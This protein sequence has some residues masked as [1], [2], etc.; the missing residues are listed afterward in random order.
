MTN[1]DKILA[2]MKELVQLEE[3]TKRLHDAEETKRAQELEV[4]KRLQ[5][6]EDTKR[7]SLVYLS[8]PQ[9]TAPSSKDGS[10]GTVSASSFFEMVSSRLESSLALNLL[11]LTV[12]QQKLVDCVCST[13]TKESDLYPSLQKVLNK[14]CEGGN[15]K[16]KDTSQNAYLYNDKPDWSFFR[17]MSQN[18]EAGEVVFLGDV[19][20]SNN[21]LSTPSTQGQ[22]LSYAQR[23]LLAQPQRDFVFVVLYNVKTFRFYRV[24]RSE[25]EIIQ[26]CEADTNDGWAKLNY[27]LHQ[28]P[29]QLGQVSKDILV[30][31]QR[32][33][34]GKVLG[35]GA[36]AAV[37]Q[38]QLPNKLNVAIKVF[39]PNLNARCKSETQILTLLADNGVTGVPSLVAH[40]QETFVMIPV[41]VTFTHFIFLPQHFSQ[42]LQI[43]SE[44]HQRSVFHRDIAP[45]NIGLSEHRV[46]LLDWSHAIRASSEPAHYASLQTAPDR[47]LHNDVIPQ[48]S[49]EDDL[50]AA[51][52]TCYMLQNRH[53]ESLFRTLL[54]K[55]MLLN[56]WQGV[57]SRLNA[58]GEAEEC[59]DR[60]LLEKL[61]GSCLLLVDLDLQ[62]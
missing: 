15:F 26:W 35:R 36:S 13:G 61:R 41:C 45:R 37:F 47:Y 7:L 30:S 16:F 34:L 6:Q 54:T 50:H 38:S 5:Q 9:D 62:L 3:E 58:F 46:I 10:A 60:G 25:T 48:A 43:I 17:S 56:F 57:R 53:K 21:S 28:S 51:L 39:K 31:G 29:Q 27:L 52:R 44:A 32:F 59:I 19:K 14:L 18:V 23:V 42:L 4:T 49:K 40:D 22:V 1:I 24:P 2:V 55:Q 12:D 20:I 33:K 8:R 11:A